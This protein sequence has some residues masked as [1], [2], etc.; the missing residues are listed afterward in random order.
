MCYKKISKDKY[1]YKK[2]LTQFDEGKS[3]NPL[4]KKLY[5]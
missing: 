5:I 1:L 3:A 4:V 2:Q